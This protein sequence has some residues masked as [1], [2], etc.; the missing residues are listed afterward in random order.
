MLW[1]TKKPTPIRISDALQR[2]ERPRRQGR[3]RY[4]MPPERGFCEGGELPTGR[5]P[6]KGDRGLDVRP[7]AVLPR[8]PVCGRARVGCGCARDSRFPAYP[9]SMS[10]G[11]ALGTVLAMPCTL[12]AG[13]FPGMIGPMIRIMLSCAMADMGVAIADSTNAALGPAA[14]AGSA[15]ECGITACLPRADTDW[16]LRNGRAE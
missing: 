10:I 15:N 4:L 13:R 12:V 7:S 6:R 2:S 16:L 5:T 8:K 9:A 11:M 14:A 1:S 3:N